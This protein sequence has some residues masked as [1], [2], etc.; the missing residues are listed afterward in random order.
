MINTGT[1]QGCILS[2]IIF[3]LVLNRI[4]RKTLGGRKIGIQWDM[5]DR[6]EDLEF[7]DDICLLAPRLTDMKEKLK[8]TARRGEVT[9][10]EY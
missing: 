10:F 8:N 4:M 1:R 3:L 5:R 9:C 6:I 7:A 2:P